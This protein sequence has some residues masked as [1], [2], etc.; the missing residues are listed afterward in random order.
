[1]AFKLFA[2]DTFFTNSLGT[3]EFDAQC[4]ILEELG[5]D[6]I[7]VALLSEVQWQ[8]LPRL[9]EVQKRYGLDV[10]AVYATLDVAADDSHQGNCRIMNVIETLEGCGSVELGL[11][12]S[13]AALK[14]S[15]PKGDEMAIALL[16]RLLKVADRRKLNVNLYPHMR[17]WMERIEDA[18]R[19]CKKM[20]H[21]RLGL[22]F[23][24]YHWFVTDGKNLGSNLE[25]AAPFL[26]SVNLCGCTMLDVPARGFFPATVELVNE[27][28]LD[29]FRVLARLREL[30]YNGI[31]GVQGYGMGGDAYSKLKQSLEALR[32]ME[33]RLNERPNWGKF[34]SG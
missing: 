30:G 21:P 29:N 26:R 11:R 22:V 6:G 5:Y 34:C 16:Q 20:N 31:V 12:S 13:D 7:H 24:G 3:Y 32:S 2:M 1:V 27:G 19:L 4:E 23:C 15:D 8:V 18:T 25:E 14:S 33:R 28:E 9:A 17:L 10:V